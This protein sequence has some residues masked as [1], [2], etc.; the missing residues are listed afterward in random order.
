[1]VGIAD[2]ARCGSCGAEMGPGAE[3]CSS[4]G[5]SLASRAPD[6]APGPSAGGTAQQ[7]GAAGRPG[8]GGWTSTPQVASQPAEPPAHRSPPPAQARPPRADVESLAGGVVE[9]QVRG[10]QQRSE[11]RGENYQVAVWTFRVE[12]YDEA[13][14][15][16]LL[17]PVEMRG[18]AFSGSLSDGDWVRA[19]G[20]VRDGTLHAGEVRNLTT[21]AVVRARNAPKALVVA[22]VVF[23]SVM[24][25]VVLSFLGWI[26]WT[27]I[28]DRGPP[29]GFPG[30]PPEPFGAQDFGDFPSGI[31]GEF[32]RGSR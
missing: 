21:G 6:R 16:S 29:E 13:G 9:G 3:T 20:T 4:C 32:P 28:T 11:Q 7:Q 15:R 25:V 19:H 2:T 18:R 12:R 26:A 10:V 17:V 23:F 8:G 31:P 30:G 27:L 24:L 1:M 5:Q 14:N 22:F